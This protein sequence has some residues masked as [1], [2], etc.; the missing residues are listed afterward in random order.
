MLN[1]KGS[2]STTYYAVLAAVRMSPQQMVPKA[3]LHGKHGKGRQPYAFTKQV[4]KVKTFAG[5]LPLPDAFPDGREW[6]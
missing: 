5:R 2:L 1:L 6:L 3:A 4:H